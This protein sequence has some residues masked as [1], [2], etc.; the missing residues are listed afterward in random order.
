METAREIAPVTIN[1]RVTYCVTSVKPLNPSLAALVLVKRGLT[2]VAIARLTTS[3][4][5]EEILP[6]APLGMLARQ[7]V[8]I[9]INALDR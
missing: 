6:K 8:I 9:M 4:T 2:I 5:K 1:V 7:T 3:S